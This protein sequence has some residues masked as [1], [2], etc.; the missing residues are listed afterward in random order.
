MKL[1]TIA[2]TIFFLFG[3]AV[4]AQENRYMGERLP[5]K[6]NERLHITL[7]GFELGPKMEDDA[8]PVTGNDELELCVAFGDQDGPMETEDGDVNCYFYVNVPNNPNEKSLL[9]TIDLQS[10]N[11]RSGDL[12]DLMDLGAPSFGLYEIDGT[13]YHPMCLERIT[14]G[15]PLYE[16]LW[17]M[18]WEL[19]DNPNESSE[20]HKFLLKDCREDDDGPTLSANFELQLKQW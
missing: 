3:T 2:T 18:H 7:E 13:E 8:F 10:K 17:K 1:F 11:L 5:L 6:H 15:Q 16:L 19:I 12:I 4:L 9:L 20:R 14:P